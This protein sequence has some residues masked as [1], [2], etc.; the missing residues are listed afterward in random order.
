[1]RL[2]NQLQPAS[3]PGIVSRD[4]QQQQLCL[5]AAM[6]TADRFLSGGDGGDAEFKLRL[7]ERL[8][9]YFIS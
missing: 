8:K 3:Q 2:I 4:G 6:T 9:E 5:P 1:M 7:A